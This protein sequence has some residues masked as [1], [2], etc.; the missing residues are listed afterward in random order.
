MTPDCYLT[1]IHTV[2]TALANPEQAAPM[3][4]YQRDQFLFLGIQ[5]PARRQA[6]AALGRVRFT[7]PELLAIADTLWQWPEREYQY[8]AVDLLVKQVKTLT[9]ADIPALLA[10]VQRKSWWDSVDGLAKV[11][12]T[13]IRAGRII[14]PSVQSLMD[15]ALQHNDFWVSR[16]ALLHQ[17]GWYGDT[18]AVRLFHYART[19]AHEKEFFIRKAIGW[20]LR[21][22]A[23]HDPQAVRAFVETHRGE[24]SGL[25]AR[26]AMKHLG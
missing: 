18:D 14:D 15:A 21:D 7:S 1:Q 25:S 22:Y 6:I 4:A 11:V 12:G 3:R 23:R 19:L 13:I 20:A 24:L 16:I 26:E 17:L 5:T 2:L 10:L 8:V 9:V